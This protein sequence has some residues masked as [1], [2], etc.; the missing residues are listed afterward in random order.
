[1]GTPPNGTNLIR[2]PFFLGLALA[3][4]LVGRPCRAYDYSSIDQHALSAPQGI[5]SSIDSLVG[6]L[7]APAK[8]DQER[9]RAVY[10]WITANIV[11]DSEGFFASFSTLSAPVAA[12]TTHVEESTD[13]LTPEM[14][15]QKGIANCE[16][17]SLLM[18]AMARRI[19][20]MTDLAQQA[21]GLE[22]QQI[23]GF[24]KGYGYRVG[25]DFSGENH[26]WNVVNL[27]G[28]W[29]MLDCTW[30]AGL[31]NEKGEFVSE[32]EDYYFLTPPEELIYTHFP[33]DPAW[34]QLDKPVSKEEFIHLAFL[35]PAYFK[36]G[37]KTVNQQESIVKTDSSFEISL[38][39]PDSILLEADLLAGNN[40]V[41]EQFTF[42]QRD[43]LDCRINALFPQAGDYTLRIFTRPT[44][45]NE[46]FKETLDYKII[47]SGGVS[48]PAGFPLTYEPFYQHKAYLHFPLSGVLHPAPSMAFKIKVPDARSVIL[49]FG[50]KRVELGQEGNL[51]TGEAPIDSIPPAIYARF[52][53]SMKYDCLLEYSLP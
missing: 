2:P 15:L 1:M 30:G 42:V 39:V 3:L 13:S 25:S 34:Q 9:L 31:P 14:V 33:T 49:M 41:E 48:G 17:Y 38:S 53:G 7:V 4:F 21:T 43:S 8:N 47:A 35:W 40:P 26:A 16:G 23:K 22:I 24:A 6:Y 51:F 32:F 20:Q 10:R 18:K 44:E 46:T 27:D 28:K 29:C 50:D 12:Q 45:K 52:P 19:R 36:Y 37:M 11:Y 5:E